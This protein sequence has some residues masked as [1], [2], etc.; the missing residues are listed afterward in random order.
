MVMSSEDGRWDFFVSYAEADREWAEWI[1]WQ[2]EA[3]N[4]RVL[5]QAWDSVPGTHSM[6]QM[7]DGIRGCDRTIAV[8]SYAYLRSMDVQAEWQAAYQRNRGGVARR[9]IPVRIEDCSPDNL[10]HGVIPFDLFGLPERQG[11]GE[12]AQRHDS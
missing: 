2:L 4:F 5:I 12:V 1:A 10:L 8:L 3:K 7:N 6:I 11:S 9:L